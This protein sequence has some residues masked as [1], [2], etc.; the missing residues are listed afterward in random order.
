MLDFIKWCESKNF[1]LPPVSE[2]ATR[3]G[4]RPYYPDAYKR[5][6]YPDAYFAPVSATAFLDLKNKDKFK[7]VKDKTGDSPLPK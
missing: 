3:T 5:A 6:Q 2:N 1:S 4:I 7:S